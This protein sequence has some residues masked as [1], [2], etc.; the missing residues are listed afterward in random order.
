M[1]SLET[2]K[3]I[4][5]EFVRNNFRDTYTLEHHDRGN[6]SG[7]FSI[8]NYELLFRNIPLNNYTHSSIFKLAVAHGFVEVLAVKNECDLNTLENE[9]HEA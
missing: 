3:F 2:V 9:S 1:D 7:K 4:K 5:R 8:V 6:E